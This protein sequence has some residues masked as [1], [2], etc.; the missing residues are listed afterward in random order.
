MTDE[1]LTIRE[2]AELLNLARKT[3]YS[4]AQRGEIPAFKVRGS[5]GSS[6]PI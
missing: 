1:V 5:G 3:D 6:A 4:I 2:V